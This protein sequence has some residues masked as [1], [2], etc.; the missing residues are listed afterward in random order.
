MQ[1]LGNDFL[2]I[3][4]KY[5]N[6]FLANNKEKIKLL[7]NRVAGVNINTANFINNECLSFAKEQVGADQVIFYEIVSEAQKIISVSIFNQDGSEACACGNG[8]RCIGK[9][10]WETKAWQN[11]TLQVYNNKQ[12]YHVQRVINPQLKLNT[13]SDE[14]IVNMGLICPEPYNP[15]LSKNIQLLSTNHISPTILKKITKY[16]NL[17]RY[18]YA[19][20]PHL[21]L[22]IKDKLTLEEI[23]ECGKML[24]PAN[25]NNHNNGQNINFVTILNENNLHLNTYERGTGCTQACGTGAVASFC[26]SFTNYIENTN[27]NTQNIEASRLNT[28]YPFGKINSSVTVH[29]DGGT[30]QVS[31]KPCRNTYNIFMQGLATI[32]F[33]G[34]IKI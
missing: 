1:A 21:V 9:Y 5:K 7:A 8:F 23:T 18:V 27:N 16:E 32:V 4:H 25:I 33:Q 31:Q 15:K 19:P 22:F 20:N 11:L 13:H 10:F 26:A 14:Y 3:S 2:I 17:T 30:L 12:K 24:E 28:K 6:Y 29:M 34:N